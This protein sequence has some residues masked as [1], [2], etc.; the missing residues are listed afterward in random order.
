[1]IKGGRV[2]NPATQFDKIADVLVENGKIVAVGEKLAAQDAEIFNAKGKIVS[3]GFIDMHIHLREPGQEAKEDFASGS[4]AAAAGGFTTVACMPNTKP[5]VDSAIL[6]NGL[7][8]RAR[9]D[10]IVNIKVIGALSKGQQGKE[11]AEVGDMLSVGAV[12]F[13]DDGHYVPSSKLLLSGLDYLRTFGGIIISHAEEQSLVEDGLMNEGHRSAMLGLKGRPTVAE[14]IAVARDILLAEYAD[15]R[16]HIAHISS[17]NAVEIVRRAKERGVKV[18]TE[19]TPHHLTLTD[20]IVDSADS[21]TKVNPPL[22]TQSDVDAMVAG[23]K[24]GTIDAIVTDH[25][26]HAYEE[27]DA[28]YMNAPSGFPGLETAVGVLLTDL[29]HTGRLSLNEIIE[30]LTYGP[31]TT[32]NLSGGVI[33]EGAVADIAIIDPDLEWIVDPT[34]FYTMGSHSPFVG[35]HM[36]GKVVATIVAGKVVMKDGEVLA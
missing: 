14:D 7:A 22:R 5:V 1:M 24:D 18:T 11:L 32:F 15:A 26:P 29:Y 21:S 13:S 23:L 4:R 27:K 34:K 35:K 2:I 9:Q 17:K 28:E 30:K 25:S 31:A 10:A 20:D 8:E 12:A 3:P 16:I 36:K 33:N 6:V 19:V